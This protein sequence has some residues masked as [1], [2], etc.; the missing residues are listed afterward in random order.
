[1][2]NLPDE[3]S[4]P[5]ISTPF[6]TRQRL[7]GI[8]SHTFLSL[9]HI[10]HNH[11]SCLERGPEKHSIRIMYYVYILLSIKDHRFYTGFTNDLK[12]RLEEHEKG[13]SIATKYRRPLR[14]VYYEVC[15]EQQD[16]LARERHLKSGRGKKYLKSRI[17]VHLHN[18]F[19]KLSKDDIV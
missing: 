12:R 14:L 16:A 9:L 13:E 8:V 15:K 17:K 18:T 19:L 6:Q 7:S 4:T 3:G 5:S 11:L 1:M 10:C 2:P